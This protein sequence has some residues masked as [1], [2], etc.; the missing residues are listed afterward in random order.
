MNQQTTKI[1]RKLFVAPFNMGDPR[2]RTAWRR[3]KR[4]YKELPWGARHLFIKGMT[5][6]R[7]AQNSSAN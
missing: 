1:L 3:F 6:L 4:T 7:A 5:N 2:N